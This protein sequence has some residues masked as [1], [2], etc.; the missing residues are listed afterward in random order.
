MNLYNQIAEFFIYI[1]SSYLNKKR[2]TGTVDLD[3][4]SK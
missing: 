3:H 2:K 1:K 4:V